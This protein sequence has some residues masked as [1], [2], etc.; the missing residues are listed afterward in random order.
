[1]DDLKRSLQRCLRQHLPLISPGDEINMAAELAFAG[2]D[3]MSAISLLLDLEQT[4]SITFPDTMLN[5]ETFRT[6]ESL[7]A[8]IRLLVGSR[9]PGC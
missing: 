9:P 5:R 6:G 4:F 1:M 2:L 8:A 7:L 3:S